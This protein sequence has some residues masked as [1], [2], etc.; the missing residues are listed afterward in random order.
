[1]QGMAICIDIPYRR[2]IRV[3][4]EKAVGGREPSK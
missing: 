2:L 4:L 3:V 1:M